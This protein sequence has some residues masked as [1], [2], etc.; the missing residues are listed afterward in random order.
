MAMGGILP[1][2]RLPQSPG[3]SLKSD[4]ARRPSP[5]FATQDESGSVSSDREADSGHRQQQQ[6]QP[7]VVVVVVVETVMGVGAWQ[8]GQEQG[9]KAVHEVGV[10]IFWRV[11]E[12]Q[13]WCRSELGWEWES[14]PILR[15]VERRTAP[16]PRVVDQRILGPTA[17][18]SR[19]E[20]TDTGTEAWER[21][22]PV[23]LFPSFEG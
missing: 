8:P 14:Q 9:V 10:L 1:H 6:Q 15:D 4:V 23:P 22:R 16:E 20:R 12:G 7:Y 17:T 18:C 3:I 19:L 5:V 13:V 11:L 2:L 21:P